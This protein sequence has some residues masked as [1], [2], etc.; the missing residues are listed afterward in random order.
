MMNTKRILSTL[1]AALLLALP[2]QASAAID[3]ASAQKL[4]VADG[5]FGWSM[6]LS[7]DG[8]T[9]LIE[10]ADRDDPENPV[11]VFVKGTNGRWSQQAKLIVKD[12]I[13]AGRKPGSVTSVTLSADGRTAFIG[14]KYYL[15]C[16]SL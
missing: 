5:P 16:N 8:G 10:G 14:H 13:T 15:M 6:S 7:A 12:E 3:P 4:V 9:V 1:A 11:Y 2:H